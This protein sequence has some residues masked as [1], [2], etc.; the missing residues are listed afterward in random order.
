VAVICL[1]LGVGGA[2]ARS[3]GQ[4]ERT[5]IESGELWR[6]VTAHFVHLGWGHLIL[7]LV[8]LALIALL[9]DDLLTDVDWIAATLAAAL[10]IDAGLYVWDNDVSW[11]VGLSGVLHGHVAL[12]AL[13][14]TL[15]RSG[16]G[17]ALALGLIG[18]IAWEQHAG[19]IPLTQASAG[20]PVVVAAHLYG[21]LGGIAAAAVTLARRR[22]ARRHAL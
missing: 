11:Y 5:G 8:A 2:A 12:G 3:W 22:V 21:A 18:K 19:P 7:N 20:G 9:F 14:L 13:L 10:A 17:A 1:V 16:V 6:L 4:Y 15:E